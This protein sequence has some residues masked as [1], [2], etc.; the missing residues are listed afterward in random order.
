MAEKHEEIIIKK[1]IKKGGGG[2]HGGAWKVAYA[3]FVSALVCLFIVLWIM[4]QSENVKSSV[5]AYF[6]NPIGDTESS[7]NQDISDQKEDDAFVLTA[8]KEKIEKALQALPFAEKIIDQIKV[9]LLEESGLGEV[10]KKA[11][12][13]EFKDTEGIEFFKSGSEAPTPEF[14]N[15]LSAVVKELVNL[16]CRVTIE[17]YTDAKPILN[18]GDFS[19]WNLSFSRANEVRKMMMVEGLNPHQIME[20][21]SYA[22]NRLA[23]PGNPESPRNRRVS[24]LILL[25]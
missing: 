3:D 19:N 13:V 4:G 2:H 14:K 1:I 24:L 20:I 15:L 25:K 12:R 9:E 7:A 6:N 17:G 21:R 5:A 10:K 23:E 18:K 16:P 22:D 8:T 11:V